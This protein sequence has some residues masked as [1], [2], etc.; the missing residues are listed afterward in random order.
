MSKSVT[1]QSRSVFFFCTW[2]FFLAVVLI[3]SIKTCAEQSHG[4]LT[5]DHVLP[6]DNRSAVSVS[7]LRRLCGPGVGV[8][9]VHGSWLNMRPRWW[10]CFTKSERGPEL[11]R[12]RH[13]K[14]LLTL[15]GS[16]D[17]MGHERAPVSQDPPAPFHT[18]PSTH[19]CFRD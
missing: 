10:S 3:I 18:L 12:L 5:L 15:Q 14:K 17:V 16:E 1:G 19:S 11:R 9:G 6:P 8:Q 2:K 13:I 4:R 7:D